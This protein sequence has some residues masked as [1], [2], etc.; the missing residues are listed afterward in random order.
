MK[1]CVSGQFFGAPNCSKLFKTV[2]NCPKTIR[3]GQSSEWYVLLELSIT[4][5]DQVNGY[6]GDET[7]QDTNA[8]HDVTMS[9][10]KDIKICF[11]CDRKKLVPHPPSLYKTLL[12]KRCRSSCKASKSMSGRRCL[13][14]HLPDRAFSFENANKKYR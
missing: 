5:L 4:E 1:T 12:S 9:G 13:F 3:Q 14:S 7:K 11:S 10:Q 6:K 2:Q 8:A